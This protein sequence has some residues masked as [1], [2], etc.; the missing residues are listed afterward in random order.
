VRALKQATIDNVI[1]IGKE[2][3]F[4]RERLSHGHFGNWLDECALGISH[5]TARRYMQ[6][7]TWADSN[8]D[9]VSVLEPTA[10][11]LLSAPSTPPGVISEVKT[12]VSQ[13]EAVPIERVRDL[14]SKARSTQ[15]R[16]RSKRAPSKSEGPAR[17]KPESA[18]AA[19]HRR[20][21]KKRAATKFARLVGERTFDVQ[22]ELVGLLARI[23]AS[24]GRCK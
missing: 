2:L 18:R 15:V 12:L 21:I 13:G 1:T 24:S 6:L 5:R 22:L 11:Y 19:R 23:S 20:K 10:A 4:A 7:A 14:V 16:A 8:S 9:T 17:G 3:I